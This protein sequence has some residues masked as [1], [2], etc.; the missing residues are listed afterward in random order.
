MNFCHKKMLK[1]INK[2]LKNSDNSSILI[3][4]NDTKLLVQC[5]TLLLL[6]KWL[7]S[8]VT[9]Q[10]QNIYTSPCSPLYR[11][12]VSRGRVST[13]AERCIVSRDMQLMWRHDLA[14]KW[15]LW[16]RIIIFFRIIAIKFYGQWNNKL[17]LMKFGNYWGNEIRVVVITL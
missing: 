15:S 1:K 4:H 3:V 2:K 16:N 5:C 9:N 13:N 17:L 12:D 6:L 11:R 10:E 14:R 8:P 7:D